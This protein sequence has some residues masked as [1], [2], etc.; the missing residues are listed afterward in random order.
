[1][2]D[3]FFDKSK[4][5][6]YQF[7]T[8]IIFIIAGAWVTTQLIAA[9]C[10]YN[11]L[12]GFSLPVP[13][14]EFR[15]Y[16]P[17]AYFFWKRDE[18]IANAI[19]VIINDHAIWQWGM[20]IP[21]FVICYAID[22]HYK[23]MSSHGTADFAKKND[24]KEIGLDAMDSGVVVGRNPFDNTIMLHNGAEHIFLAAPTRSGKTVGAVI[25]TGI[26]WKNSIFFFDP[27]AEV[28]ENTS[29]YRK[30]VLKQKTIKF[31]PLCKD[32]SGA[33]WNPYAE[34]YF[35]STEEM[36]DITTIN[37]TMVQTGESNSKDPFWDNSAIG[38]LN[39]VVLHLLYKHYQ[40]KRLLPCPTDTMSFLSSPT[41]N[42]DQLFASMKIYPHIS[43]EEFLE[44]EYD[45]E[46]IDDKGEKI[47]IHRKY[48]NILSEI[49]T[50]YIQDLRP[51]AQE[52]EL[53]G[54]QI[55]CLDDVKKAILNKYR[56]DD[57]NL[58]G[59]AIH[60]MIQNNEKIDW[61]SIDLNVLQDMNSINTALSLSAPF[62]QLL[63]HPKVAEC[64]ATILNGAKDTR[65]SIIQSAQTALIL[66]QDP[67]IKKNTAVSDFCFKDLLNPA[68]AVSLYL[69]LQPNDIIKL[70]PLTR[71][72]VNTMLAKTVRDMKFDQPVEKKQ[73]LLLMLD[74]FPQLK[75]MEA[76]ENNLV[77]CAG[78]GVKICI[79][80]QSTTQLNAIYTK[81]NIIL[82]N[83]HVQIYYTP[84]KY[85][86]AKALSDLLGERTIK[87]VSHSSNGSLTGGSSSTS[88]IARQLLK[89][90]EVMRMSK[91]KELIFIPGS[92]PILAKK[93]RWYNEEFF[94]KRCKINP[95]IFSDQFT[96]V[97][98]F[99]MLFAVYA[100]ES[101]D[102]I[103]K[104]QKVTSAKQKY[105]ENNSPDN[106]SSKKKA[107]ENN[108]EIMPVTPSI[109]VK[110][111]QKIIVSENEKKED[112]VIEPAFDDEPQ[113]ECI[114]IREEEDLNN[115][116]DWFSSQNNKGYEGEGKQQEEASLVQNNG[117]FVS[118]EAWNEGPEKIKTA[119]GFME[120][121]QK[122]KKRFDKLEYPTE[123][124]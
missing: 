104:Q 83:S 96:S 92:K 62:Y 94:K 72:F 15:I 9:D 39:G 38:L 101:A 17:F 112:N 26:I 73:R 95:P 113:T 21:A 19:T 93:I 3:D 107:I 70:R 4:A 13:F 24:I 99:E 91:N 115:E 123:D 88:Q 64:A 27:K 10:N 40:E 60:K 33:R 22:K 45:E 5:F 122:S 118:Q 71:L 31:E 110:E 116:K 120:W 121:K 68:Q 44:L 37:T 52:L 30:N 29:G 98:N 111:N 61:T 25:P 82:D 42:T 46:L 58:D 97:E 124:E 109:T 47:T 69:V 20:L 12:L 14:T 102:L 74:E 23:V 105:N 65:A 8:L 41:L 55:N 6:K 117:R 59:N 35:Q 90:D 57:P 32:G 67:L 56:E 11:R 108:T 16:E 43:P 76:I 89:P 75:K 1:M 66:Y 77:I 79:V 18:V 50:E 106:E 86:A 78:F 85:E 81:D 48:K 51:F 7:V 80:A 84:T 114:S 63:V 103:E 100:P 49:Y 87:S 53:G 119:S 34:I 2:Q 28:W 54:K 36:S